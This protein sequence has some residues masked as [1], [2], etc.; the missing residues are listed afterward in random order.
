[1]VVMLL[2]EIMMVMVL[3]MVVTIF[4]MIV[5]KVCITLQTSAIKG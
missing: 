1:M 3:V 4:A 2:L 5:L